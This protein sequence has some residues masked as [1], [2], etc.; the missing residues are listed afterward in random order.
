MLKKRAEK[1]QN[2]YRIII[3]ISVNS[4]FELVCLFYVYKIVCIFYN[5]IENE[6]LRKFDY[7]RPF[8]IFYLYLKYITFN[9]L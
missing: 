2:T 3:I 6:F 8:F 1:K 7:K 4:F 5:Y 9:M